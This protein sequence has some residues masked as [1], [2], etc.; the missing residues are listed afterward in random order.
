MELFISLEVIIKV[1]YYPMRINSQQTQVSIMNAMDSNIYYYFP[2][3]HL[4]SN[5]FMLS[6]TYIMTY[7]GNA[8]HPPLNMYSRFPQ[9]YYDDSKVFQ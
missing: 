2:Y 9:S 6:I 3:A 1:Y 4:I 7:T 8:S 5:S